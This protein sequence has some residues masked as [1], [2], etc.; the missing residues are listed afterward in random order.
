MKQAASWKKS[1]KDYKKALAVLKNDVERAET[2]KLSNNEKKGTIQDFDQ[3]I[4]L[5]WDLMKDYLA[6]HGIIGINESGEAVRYAFKNN[7]IE[8]K[9]VWMD[10]IKEHKLVS[11]ETDGKT[12]DELLASIVNSYYSLFSVLEERMEELG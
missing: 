8:D 9:Q 2:R 1:F 3:T 7:L 12:A 11:Q 5:A 10:M 6:D 4:G